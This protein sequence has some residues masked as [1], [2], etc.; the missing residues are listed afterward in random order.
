M[1]IAIISKNISNL[2]Y[3]IIENI[4]LNTKFYEEIIY[5]KKFTPLTLKGSVDFPFILINQNFFSII[6]GE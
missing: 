3:K 2:N 1:L 6:F 4:N 5:D